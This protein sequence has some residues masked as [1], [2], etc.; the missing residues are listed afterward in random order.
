MPRNI[1]TRIL[2]GVPAAAAALTLVACT[3]GGI[4]RPSAEELSSGIS[5]IL[6][7]VGQDGVYTEEQID[8]FAEKFLV[9]QLP[10]QDLASLAAG[11]DEQSSESVKALVTTTMQEATVTCTAQ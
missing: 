10:D 8:C 1:F 11:R 7:N 3:G 5:T 2:L 4:Q 6:T 9:A